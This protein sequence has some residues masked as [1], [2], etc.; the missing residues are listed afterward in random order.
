M[1]IYQMKQ[2]FIPPGLVDMDS[3]YVDLVF[4]SLFDGT[5]DQA[6]DTVRILVDTL[7]TMEIYDSIDCS[8]L[9][10]VP[11]TFS[12]TDVTAWVWETTSLGTF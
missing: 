6:Y 12:G 3:G 4:A 8:A 1:L 11:L 7:P 5:C 9:G 10:P 2:L